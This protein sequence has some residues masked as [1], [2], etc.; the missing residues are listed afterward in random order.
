M[1]NTKVFNAD[2]LVIDV[3]D[4]SRIEAR[5]IIDVDPPKNCYREMQVIDNNG[6][7]ITLRLYSDDVEKLKI[8]EEKQG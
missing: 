2:S 3:M 1:I 8:K 4:V 5:R 6:R 7:G